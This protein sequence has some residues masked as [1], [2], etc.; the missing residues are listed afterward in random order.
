MPYQKRTALDVNSSVMAAALLQGVGCFHGP[1]EHQ[2]I[3]GATY[4]DGKV[5]RRSTTAA[6][7][8]QALCERILDA[9]EAHFKAQTAPSR[10]L[11]LHA[12]SSD[13]WEAVRSI[14]GIPWQSR[15]SRERGTTMSR[16]RARHSS[17][18]G[19]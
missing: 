14:F 10:H 1:G 9:A 12:A 5:V 19:D 4:Q 7:W 13:A 8:P 11:A 3:E 6:A 16:L 15:I 17:S 18:L 2:H